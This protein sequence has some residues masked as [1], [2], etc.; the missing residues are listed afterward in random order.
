MAGIALIRDNTAVTRDNSHKIGR[1][2]GLI[3]AIGIGLDDL[4]DGLMHVSK[5]SIGTTERLWRVE[6]DVKMLKAQKPGGGLLGGLMEIVNKKER[7]AWVLLVLGSLVGITSAADIKHKYRELV[8]LP[9]QVSVS[10]S[11][12]SQSSSSAPP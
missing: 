1:C 5:Q 11:G 6:E 8:G 9:P 3:E 12:S 2:M 4:R 10:H 7:A